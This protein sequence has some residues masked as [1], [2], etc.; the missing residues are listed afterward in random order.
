MFKLAPVVL[1]SGV[2]GLWKIDCDALSDGDWECLAYMAMEQMGWPQIERVIGVPTGGL[3][4]ARG[5]ERYTTSQG[6]LLLVDDV[7]T[8]G[9]SMRD[10]FRS[11]NWSQYQEVKGL[12]VFARGLCPAW[13][14]PIFQIQPPPVAGDG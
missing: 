1:H 11:E 12:V 6:C 9:Q 8:T 2:T 10:M 14:T 13:V 4:L 5:L 3:K 7:L